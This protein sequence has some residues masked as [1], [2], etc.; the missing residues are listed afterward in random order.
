ML[1]AQ[2]RKGRGPRFMRLTTVTGRRTGQPHSTPVVPVEAVGE[3]WVVAP[4]GE[5][6]WVRNVRAVRR[7]TLHRGEVSDKSTATVVEPA[8]AVPM[9]RRYLAIKPAGRFVKSYFDVTPESPR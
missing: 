1:S 8:Q 2:L 6:G 3:R 4:F 5:V 9:V 7:L